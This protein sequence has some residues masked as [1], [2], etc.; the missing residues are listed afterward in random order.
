MA[1]IQ[2]GSLYDQDYYRWALEQ[3]RAVQTLRDAAA[4]PGNNLPAALEA[5]D[6][7]NL[8][9]E[10]EGL[11]KAVRAELR[12]RIITVVKHLVKLELSPAS[13]PKAG[14]KNTIGRSRLDIEDLLN[15]NPSL[16]REIAAIIQAPTMA[17]AAKLAIDELFDRGEVA[18]RTPPPEYDQSQ[19]LEDWWPEQ[20]GNIP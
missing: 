3:A 9:E 4:R 5:L 6:W 16:R 1:D 8:V 15:D 10:L 7:D 2:E 20:R 19:I 14:W 17:K 11:A 12:N 18:V 13:D